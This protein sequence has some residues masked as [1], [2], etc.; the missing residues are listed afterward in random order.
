MKDPGNRHGP[1]KVISVTKGGKQRQ[2]PLRKNEGSLWELAQRYQ[3]QLK[4]LYEFQRKA[5]EIR[6]IIL[7]VLE[8]RLVP[9]P[10][11]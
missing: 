9:F 10:N 7:E 8:K 11:R 1:Y 3:Y 4:Q 6:K 5:A 2:I